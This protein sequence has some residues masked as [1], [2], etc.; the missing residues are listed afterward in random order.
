M[1]DQG[2]FVPLK[3]VWEPLFCK[4]PWEFIFLVKLGGDFLTTLVT[5]NW[6]DPPSRVPKKESGGGTP[7]GDEPNITS[8][9]N[10]YS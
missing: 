7:L 9:K 8:P 3:V 6:D 1:G 10:I 4:R 5:G 2:S